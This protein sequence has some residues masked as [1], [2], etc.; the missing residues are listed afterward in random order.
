MIY[1][2]WQEPSRNDLLEEHFLFDNGIDFD[3]V[4]KLSV[5]SVLR[6]R[7]FGD[8]Y[9]FICVILLT[10]IWVSFLGICFEVGAGELPRLPVWNSLELCFK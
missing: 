3:C 6:N 8:K 2:V 9:Q 7:M 5:V 1:K 10:L 4:W